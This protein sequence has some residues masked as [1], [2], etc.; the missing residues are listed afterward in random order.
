MDWLRRLSDQQVVPEV[1]TPES[2]N[3]API[4]TEEV[5][6][7]S[8][9]EDNPSSANEE[10]RHTFKFQLCGRPT[11]YFV[12][13]ALSSDPVDTKNTLPTS[14]SSPGQSLRDRPP[15]FLRTP[16][17]PGE[18][19]ETPESPVPGMQPGVVQSEAQ[20]QAARRRE[21]ASHRRV[22][23]E[24][25]LQH[26]R[27]P[28]RAPR[29]KHEAPYSKVA[30]GLGAPR[31]PRALLLVLLREG[32]RQG[33]DATESARMVKQGQY[34]VVFAFSLTDPGHGAG[35]GAMASRRGVPREQPQPPRQH[36][37][38]PPAAPDVAQHFAPQTVALHAAP[39]GASGPRFSQ[40]FQSH[41][42]QQQH[43]H[44]P[45][46]LP[47]RQPSNTASAVAAVAAA[48]AAPASARAA[49]PVL[50]IRRY[51]PR[52]PRELRTATASRRTMEFMATTPPRSVKNQQMT[53]QKQPLT[54]M[55]TNMPMQG[56]SQSVTVHTD[57]EVV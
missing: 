55:G 52:R 5:E 7:F 45:S 49:Q 28:L 33:R 51:F 31:L 37:P 41:G 46:P 42:Q 44:Q 22:P 11:P 8:E 12:F 23:P 10:D 14:S 38:L 34:Q 57:A 2:D 47:Q 56:G 9:K 18:R 36:S 25:H 50:G 3:V 24:E 43:Q 13:E 29:R 35:H 26:R 19:L 4:V 53:K 6:S 16:H 15:T 17:V 39:S 1:F 27:Q 40:W 48:G 21:A 54:V 20:L 30:E 32:S